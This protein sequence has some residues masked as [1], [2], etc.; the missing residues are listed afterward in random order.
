MF[1]DLFE[2]I[3]ILQNLYIKNKC[4]LKKKSYSMDGEDIEIS[5]YFNN[6]KNGFYVDVGAY[7][8]IERNNTM[9]LYLNGWEGINIDISDFSIKLFNH[10]R[11]KD[12][13]L[14][15]AISKK[16]G[17]VEM[18]YQKKLSQ[19]STIKKGHAQKNF[20]GSIKT[21]EISSKT[22]TSVLNNSKFKEKKI[23]FLDIDVEGAD[24]DV[25]ESLDFNLYSPELI[26]VEVI[27]KNNEES[28][29]FNF[30]KNKGYQKIWS[31][32]FSHVFKRT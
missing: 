10:L 5:N 23:D 13:N 29:I 21:K 32:V 1:S 9:L 19:L 31:G 16:E 2:K 27:E 4:F 7:H 15:L 28:Q 24:I 6:K 12:N 22:L 8:P 30:L 25:L 18:F 3:H 20:Q 17:S 14:N 11:P 26:C